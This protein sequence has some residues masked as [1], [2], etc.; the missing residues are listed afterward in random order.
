MEAQH[1]MLSTMT[2]PRDRRRTAAALEA[3]ERHEIV[4]GEL[5]QKASPTFAHGATQISIGVALGGFRGHGRPGHP[6]GWWLG[7]E[8]EIELAPQE[9]YLPDLAGWRID[10]VPEP[11]RERPVRIAPDWV[12]E[13][14]S[15]STTGR[16]LGHKRRSYHLARVGHYWV[17]EPT[18]QTLTVYRWQEAGYLLAMSASAGEMARVEPF[19]VI[20]LDIG[21]MFGLPPREQ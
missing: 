19:D 18:S 15:P 17:V 2:Q 12:C 6:G 9:V 1:G 21:D 10:R 3:L 4:G 11:P 8:V 5:V 14:L 20:E 16:D 7:A 13:V